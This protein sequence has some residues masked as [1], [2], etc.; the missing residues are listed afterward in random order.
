[1][2]NLY[3]SQFYNYNTYQEMYPDN[4]AALD[5]KAPTALANAFA[6]VLFLPHS[7][8]SINSY[9]YIGYY[10]CGSIGSWCGPSTTATLTVLYQGTGLTPSVEAITDAFYEIIYAISTQEQSPLIN[11]L[12]KYG[13]PNAGTLNQINGYRLA[14]NSHTEF[15]PGQPTPAPVP[16]PGPTGIMYGTTTLNANSHGD[17][18]TTISH[19]NYQ[20]GENFYWFITPPVGVSNSTKLLYTIHFPVFGM[21]NSDELYLQPYQQYGFWENRCYGSSCGDIQIT[22]TT[23]IILWF[24]SWGGDSYYYSSSSM[25]GFIAQVT[26]QIYKPRKLM[27]SYQS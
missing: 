19:L 13:F 25:K 21:T 17:N 1:M 9:N 20:G 12:T 7:A 14:S 3:F 11:A 27:L 26:W 4:T 15:L 16:T 24:N 22:S 2:Q 8:V 6:D 5:P 18:V 23:G 10:G